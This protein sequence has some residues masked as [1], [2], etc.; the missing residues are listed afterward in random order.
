MGCYTASNQTAFIK[1][2]YILES[3]VTAHEVLHSIH[4]SGEPGIGLKLDYE[5]A[6]HKV[7]LDFLLEVLE[8]RNFSPIWIHWIRMITHGR[9]VGVKVNV[10]EGGFFTT[11]K[12][13]R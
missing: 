9:Y 12:G 3:V 1:G 6:F 2:R 4:H 13:L 7:N 8:K 5:K 10:V 11:G